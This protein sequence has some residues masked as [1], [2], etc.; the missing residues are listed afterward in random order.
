MIPAS[1]GPAK[2]TQEPARAHQAF[3]ND[4]IQV[5]SMHPPLNYAETVTR[6][7]GDNSTFSPQGRNQILLSATAEGSTG[8]IVTRKN[9]CTNHATHV[10]C[11]HGAK[12]HFFHYPPGVVVSNLASRDP[13]LLGPLNPSTAMVRGMPDLL[14]WD[15]GQLTMIAAAKKTQMA[16]V[17]AQA[18][19]K[20]T[21]EEAF[22]AENDAY[23]AALASLQG[24]QPA[25]KRARI[26]QAP[27]FMDEPEE[28]DDAPAASPEPQSPPSPVYTCSGGTHRGHLRAIRRGG[29]GW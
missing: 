27:V 11:S 3:T 4:G 14:E 9:A 28:F 22:N 26:L 19:S 10:E 25:I 21:A 23:A 13:V 2:W 12:C 24:V 5:V 18:A 15:L 20:R 16:A 29:Y 6:V 8:I 17:M 1:D 7:R